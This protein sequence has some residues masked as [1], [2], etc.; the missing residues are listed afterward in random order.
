M[1]E[2]GVWRYDVTGP[3]V[4]EARERGALVSMTRKVHE[5]VWERCLSWSAKDAARWRRFA[6]FEAL[7]EAWRTATWS[8]RGKSYVFRLKA[9]PLALALAILDGGGAFSG[10][11][12]RSVREQHRDL[13][14]L[15]FAHRMPVNLRPY[16][17][18]LPEADRPTA[19]VEAEG[20]PQTEGR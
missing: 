6:G 13:V 14:R 20:A 15:T 16:I 1:S 3:N 4:V 12:Y 17:H 7:R 10:P 8:G 18:C 2:Q 5:A 19:S 11:L 9:E